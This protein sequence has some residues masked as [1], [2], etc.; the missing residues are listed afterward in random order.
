MTIAVDTVKQKCFQAAFEHFGRAY[1]NIYREL[2]LE[3][4]AFVRKFETGHTAI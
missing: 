3:P 2:S 4:T 1:H